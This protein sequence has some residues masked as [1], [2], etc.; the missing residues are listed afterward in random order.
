MRDYTGPRKFCE[1]SPVRADG[2]CIGCP[3]LMGNR[4]EGTSNIKVIF[5]KAMFKEEKNGRLG[6]AVRNADS[7]LLFLFFDRGRDVERGLRPPCSRRLGGDVSALSL[8]IRNL[9]MHGQLG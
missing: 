4:L 3:K 8:S 6:S 5:C 1:V 2:L 7:F 9:C